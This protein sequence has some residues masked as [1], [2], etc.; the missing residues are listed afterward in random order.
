MSTSGIDADGPGATPG[1]LE[2]VM[3]G[4]RVGAGAGWRWVRRGWIFFARAPL[5]WVI[6]V[7]LLVLVALAFNLVPIVGSL[8]YQVLQ[9]VIAAGFVAA[10]RSLEQGGDFELEHLLAGFKERFGPLMMLGLL[11]MLGGLVI[12]LVMLLFVGTAILEAF[13]AGSAGDVYTAL[14]ASSL[15]MLL[16]AL[17]ALA[18]TV[19]L[20]AAFWF[21]PALVL[22]NGVAPFAAMKA[23]LSA[24]LRNIMPFLVYGVVMMVAAI[25]AAIPLL[26][27]FLVWVPVMLA[28]GYASYRDVFTREAPGASTSVEV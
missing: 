9:G 14:A 6:S 27:G 22:L 23:S 16:G 1:D 21:A 12:M 8:A 13:V 25:L 20:L 19:P 5:M 28:S 10:C 4:R 18:L 17:V 3:P 26:L 15:S 2:L 24:S 7:V 11:F